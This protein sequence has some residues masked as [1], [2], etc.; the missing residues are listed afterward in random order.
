MREGRFSSGT[1]TD[2]D[3]IDEMLYESARRVLRGLTP[4]RFT[5]TVTSV[6]RR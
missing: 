6:Y 1:E 4:R 5:M 3:D 2:E